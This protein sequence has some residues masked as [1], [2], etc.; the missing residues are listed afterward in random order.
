MTDRPLTR[1]ASAAIAGESGTDLQGYRDYR[2][3]EVFGAWKWL[4]GL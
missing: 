1:M 3:V 2:G 4:A